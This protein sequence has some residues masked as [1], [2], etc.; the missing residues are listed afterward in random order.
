MARDP[1]RVQ[2]LLL[3][4]FLV[5]IAL[6]ACVAILIPAGRGWDFANFYD[7]GSRAAAGQLR[8]IYNPGSLIHG[9]TPQGQMAFWGAPISAW[10]Y[11]PL[12]I[13]S[14]A[15]ALVL[16]KLVATLSFGIGLFLLYQLM[17]PYAERNSTT[18]VLWYSTT[19]AALILLYQPF[20][21]IFRVGGQTTPIAFLFLVLGLRY[22]L[23]A[24]YL[25]TAL[26]LLLVVL[27]K[28]AFVFVPAV[29][30]L[31]SGRR[32]FL[33]I[34][35]VFA[36]TAVASVLL[37][38]LPIHREF[39]DIL[40]RGSEKP[41]P[42]PFN[43]SLYIL[44]DVLRPVSHSI[45]VVRAGGW[46]PDALRSVM[47]FLVLG[48][49][50]TLSLGSARQNWTGERRRLFWYLM[51]I[52]FTLLISQ[53]VWEHYL[54]V[55]FIPL[56]FLVALVPRMT[57]VAR[58]H[59]ALIFGLSVLQNLILVLFVR[60]HIPITNSA[61]LLLVSAVKAGPLLAYLAF[62]WLRRNF[63]FQQVALA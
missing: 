40:R 41:S 32:F 2:R 59:L 45:P 35:G 25:E 15:V 52:S 57:S 26:C 42:W 51:A 43:S 29:L 16:L 14:P 39:L 3:R 19:F 22:H 60:D 23:R 46:I 44:A 18:T 28:P 12:S 21:T 31:V 58:I 36:V 47:K 33:S 13:F 20:W 11:T 50:V 61:S 38:G 48:V 53:V 49:F 17:K 63:L 27:V 4:F 24:K 8:D 1:V 5:L 55:L 30:A 56:A 34:A 37:F 7:T 62:L 6:G 9:Q 10:L 54:A